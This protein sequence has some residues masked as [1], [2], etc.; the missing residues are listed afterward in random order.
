[1]EGQTITQKGPELNL[2]RGLKGT[3]MSPKPLIQN[4]EEL[5]RCL[6]MYKTQKDVAAALGCAMSTVYTSCRRLG[7]PTVTEIRKG[8]AKGETFPEIFGEEE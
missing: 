1:M 7:L 4:R 5:I 8:L 2:T 6:R 3:E